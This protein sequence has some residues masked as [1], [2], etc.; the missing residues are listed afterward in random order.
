MPIV[1]NIWFEIPFVHISTKKQVHSK[2][3]RTSTICES[4]CYD[5][6]KKFKQRWS[7]SRDGSFVSLPRS[8]TSISSSVEGKSWTWATIAWGSSTLID[9]MFFANL[10]C[11]HRGGKFTWVG[12]YLSL[13]SWTL[14]SM[15][16]MLRTMN[17]ANTFLWTWTL[18]S[19]LEGWRNKPKQ[20]QHCSKGPLMGFWL[21]EFW[22]I[23]AEAQ[24]PA[25]AWY[26][27]WDLQHQMA[28]EDTA[29][30]CCLQHS[31]RWKSAS[32]LGSMINVIS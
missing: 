12:L 20:H 24:R 10:W 8:P 5:L 28:Q 16:K 31:A 27:P 18:L 2:S 23:P 3:H 4:T 30:L 17:E 14:N 22:R 19:T 29:T 21:M 7:T 9:W 1:L 26:A 25:K 13:F 15:P 11:L 6:A 32:P